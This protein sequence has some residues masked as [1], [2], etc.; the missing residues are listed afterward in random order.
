M[1]MPAATIAITASST[2]HLQPNQQTLNRP[3]MS[4]SLPAEL[5]RC[6]RCGCACW[7]QRLSIRN[8]GDRVRH[9]NRR[10]LASSALQTV[11]TIGLARRLRSRIVDAG[12]AAGQA[13][14]RVRVRLAAVS[15]PV[16][17][18][19]RA[20]LVNP[21]GWRR[22]SQTVERPARSRKNPAFQA[23]KAFHLPQAV[24]ILVGYLHC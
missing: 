12:G 4:K 3:A 2:P 14:L 18:T 17:A 6:R 21:A 22:Q 24:A 15:L 11:V 9:A 5:K 7:A 23:L 13:R 16:P 8:R 19:V 20:A 10:R 1:Y